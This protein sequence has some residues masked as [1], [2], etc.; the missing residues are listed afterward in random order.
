MDKESHSP[1]LCDQCQSMN[2]LS[3]LTVKPGDSTTLRGPKLIQSRSLIEVRDNSQYCNCCYLI[4]SAFGPNESLIAQ[5]TDDVDEKWMIWVQ[6]VPFARF[7]SPG[8]K[9]AKRHGIWSTMESVINTGD[10]ESLKNHVQGFQ[11]LVQK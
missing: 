5:R 9:T 1:E 3:L 11:L 10:P 2:L 6:L 8:N 4:I 7:L